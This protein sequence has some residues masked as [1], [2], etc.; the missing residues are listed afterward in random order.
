MKLF[1]VFLIMD[2]RIHNYEDTKKYFDYSLK[3]KQRLSL[4][5]LPQKPPKPLNPTR[6]KQAAHPL[7]VPLTLLQEPLHKKKAAIPLPL[8][9]AQMVCHQV[10]NTI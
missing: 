6:A 1:S 2:V 9:A 7:R 8:V 10:K 3:Q 4:L 5:K